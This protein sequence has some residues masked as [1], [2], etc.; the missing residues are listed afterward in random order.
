MLSLM[1]TWVNSWTCMRR[2]VC[3]HVCVCKAKCEDGNEQMNRGQGKQPQQ[4]TRRYHYTIP[5]LQTLSLSCTNTQHRQ[6][7]ADLSINLSSDANCEMILHP[8][9]EQGEPLDH[10]YHLNQSKLLF[11]VV[12][13]ACSLRLDDGEYENKS[14]AKSANMLHVQSQG[15]QNTTEKFAPAL[16]VLKT[17]TN[18]TY[19]V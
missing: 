12:V 9:H 2:G 16:Q 5:S 15:S 10:A 6:T 8:V 13:V 7:G 19:I 11:W 14:F 3:A 4:L 18:L 1:V 17:V